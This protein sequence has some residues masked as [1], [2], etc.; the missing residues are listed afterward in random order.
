VL[1]QRIGEL[2]EQI[3]CAEAPGKQM[4][5]SLCKPDL[6]FQ[7]DHLEVVPQHADDFPLL[8]RNRPRSWPLV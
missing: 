4:P 7:A 3:R 8:A 5:H 2:Q 1:S 6:R